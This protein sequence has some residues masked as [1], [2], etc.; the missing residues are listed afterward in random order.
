M[1]AGLKRFASNRSRDGCDPGKFNCMDPAKQ[2]ERKRGI[3]R[4]PFAMQI[5]KAGVAPAWSEFTWGRFG[6]DYPSREINPLEM[7]NLVSPAT[8]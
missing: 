7:A 5:K 6:G 3:D 1:T 4:N 2:N 8:L